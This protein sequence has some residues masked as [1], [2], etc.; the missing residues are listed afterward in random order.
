VNCLDT[1]VVLFSRVNA[2]VTCFSF[3]LDDKTSLPI[4]V[5]DPSMVEIPMHTSSDHSSDD[6][7]PSIN[8]ISIH[9]MFYQAATHLPPPGTSLWEHLKSRNVSF[10]S[11]L[12]LFSDLS[13]R[14][15][16]LC[17]IPDQSNPGT[18]TAD[19]RAEIRPTTWKRTGPQSAK[20]AALQGFIV[21]DGL[22]DEDGDSQL[23]PYRPPRWKDLKARSHDDDF[24]RSSH[25]SGG[26]GLDYRRAYRR[27]CAW[28]T[29]EFDNLDESAT[30]SALFSTPPDESPVGLL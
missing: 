9:S 24:D 21:P 23:V 13:L 6:L 1:I 30:A 28:T 27:I 8:S 20:K 12:V 7:A 22:L 18:G 29:T 26:Y 2:I 3:F 11:M 25:A 10:Y 17:S 19:I 15:C 4:S 16:F 14:R 5:S